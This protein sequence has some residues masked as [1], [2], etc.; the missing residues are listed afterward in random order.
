MQRGCNKLLS[1]SSPVLTCC[2][3]LADW[4]CGKS[5]LGKK[6]VKQQLKCLLNWRNDTFSLTVLYLLKAYTHHRNSCPR[7]TC[8]DFHSTFAY[9]VFIVHWRPRCTYG[10]GVSRRDETKTE[11]ELQTSL[12]FFLLHLPLNLQLPQPELSVFATICNRLQRKCC[13][14]AVFVTFFVC[15]LACSA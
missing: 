12:R 3:S 7:W 8:S 9:P 1:I 6:Q 4:V 5:N 13:I 15:L 14:R 2:I 11:S 10:L